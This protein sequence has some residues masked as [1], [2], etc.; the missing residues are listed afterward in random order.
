L[1]ENCALE[2]VAFEL[3]NALE[4]EVEP[5]HVLELGTED[6]GEDERVGERDAEV[7][8]EAEV[9]AQVEAEVRMGTWK[10]VMERRNVAAAAAAAAAVV[11]C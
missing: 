9:E 11:V 10:F 5:V 3:E 4:A 1:S 2:C 6:E 8:V 7:E